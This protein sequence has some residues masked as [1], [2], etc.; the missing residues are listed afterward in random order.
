VTQTE[1]NTLTPRGRP[2]VES[3]A[4]RAEWQAIV[5]RYEHADTRR[6]LAQLATTILPLCAAFYIMYRSLALPYWVTLLLSL[7]TAGFL[8]RTFIIMHDCAHRSFLRWGRVNDAIGMITG[9]ITMTP[10]ER[11]RRDHARHHASSGDLDRRGHGDIPTLTVREYLARTPWGRFRYRLYRHPMVLIGLGPLHMIVLQR[12]PGG[13]GGA[14][15]RTTSNV[16]V[17]NA[18]ILVTFV[19]FS[20]WIGVRAVLLI[21]LPAMY[22]AAVAGV[23]LFYVQHQFEDAYWKDHAEWD[24]ATAAIRGSSYFK[25]PAILRWITGSIGLHH[26]HH[27]GPRVPNYRLQRCHDENA[28]FHDVTVLT[29]GQ[30]ARTLRLSL[31]DEDAGRLIAFS[32]LSR[33]TIAAA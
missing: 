31:W 28:L 12:F 1:T 32:E 3:I 24:Y 2:A 18:A 10:F 33:A 7:P 21:Y 15:D 4:P 5:A 11:W 30:S 20:M 17:T 25:L 26:V 8:V 9:I 29:I 16:W 19:A 6:S 27:L 13:E 14:R 22:L 23:W